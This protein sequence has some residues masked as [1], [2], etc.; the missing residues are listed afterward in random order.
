[1][2]HEQM[3][4]MPVQFS[5]RE[6]EVISLL[7]K[8][9]KFR[10]GFQGQRLP[11][12]VISHD[13]LII[14]SY[15]QDFFDQKEAFASYEA[16]G[17]PIYLFA[18]LGWHRETPERAIELAAQVGALAAIAPSVRTSF[19]C[20]SPAEESLISEQG[21]S[22]THCHQNA[23]LDETRYRVT[24][25]R[26]RPYEAVYVARITPFKRHELASGI[27]SLSLIGDWHDY[28]KDYKDLVM[29]TLPSA[30]WRRRVPS[31]LIY[32]YMNAAQT[33]LCL[34]AEEGAMFVSA[35]Y[36]LCGLP[37]VSTPNL[38]GRDELFT[39]PFA[40]TAA[41]SAEA[42]SE[43]VAWQIGQRH[44]PLDIRQ[45]VIEKMH[46]HRKVFQRLVQSIYDAQRIDRDFSSEWAAV[47]THKLG[48]RCSVSVPR[49]WRRGLVKRTVRNSDNRFGAVKV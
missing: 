16:M 21:L 24:A 12:Y 30:S 26:K 35:E 7:N 22:C 1:L 34:S 4:A 2:H 23:F 19:L 11:C 27:G 43:A 37:V 32:R 28:E 6:E 14:V 8:I 38:G 46:H 10:D 49:R 39:E 40:L 18:M 47:Y 25:A 44:N 9:R 13:P 17:R 29:Q 5:I 33:G 15:W 41:P 42:V 48:I 36:L 3:I 45:A 20:N 31:P